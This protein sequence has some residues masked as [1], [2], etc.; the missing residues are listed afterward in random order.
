MQ[1]QNSNDLYLKI[2]ISNHLNFCKHFETK[3]YQVF[4]FNT[5]L[6]L[7]SFDTSTLFATKL[8]A[9][10]YRHRERKIGNQILT[11]KGRDTY[12]LFWYLSNGYKPNLDCIQDISDLEDLKKKLIA[13]VEATD[14]KVVVEDVAHFMEDAQ[15]LSFL[16]TNGK[17]YLIEQIKAL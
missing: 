17:S 10:L 4:K 13:T 6:V 15:L 3:I 8:N 7:Q 5:S 14:F 16:E 9:V 2:E 11:M 1:Y 12:D